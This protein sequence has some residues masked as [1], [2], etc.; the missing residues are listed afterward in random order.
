M[1]EERTDEKDDH[2]DHKPQ[3][4]N[5]ILITV[6]PVADHTAVHGSQGTN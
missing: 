6:C 5:C 4:L 2:T 3:T 1:M